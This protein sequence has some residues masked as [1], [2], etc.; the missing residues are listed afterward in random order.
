[1][2]PEI[3]QLR[4]LIVIRRDPYLN[5]LARVFKTISKQENSFSL[6][7]R[8]RVSSQVVT[9]FFY[10]TSGCLFV[11]LRFTIIHLNYVKLFL[12]VSY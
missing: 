4:Q 10:Q 9:L 8:M 11:P 2:S 6:F 3:R 7:P 12:E 5:E 1:M